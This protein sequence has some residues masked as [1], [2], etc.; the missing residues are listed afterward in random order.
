VN[1][2]APSI[3]GTMREG[4]T[5]T[6]DK[7]S[8][9][10][11]D[12][13]SYAYQWRRCNS[14]GSGCADVAG[15]TSGTYVLSTADS[16]RAVAVRVTGTNNA[17]SSSAASSSV[18]LRTPLFADGFESGL[19][20]WTN[21]GL[22]TWQTDAF[23][24]SSS[25]RAFSSAG[26]ASYA[27]A[28]LSPAQTDLTYRLHFKSNTAS[29]PSTGVYLLKMR[30]AANGSVVG[31]YVTSTGRLSYRNDVGAVA[32]SSPV[33]LTTGEWHEV[34][35]H[36]TIAGTSSSIDLTLDGTHVPA[37]PRT[38][39]FGTAAIGKIQVGDNSTGRNFDVSA[40][41]A[42]VDNGS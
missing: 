41:E 16:G 4:N 7:G 27:T 13:I 29:W 3:S 10:G 30:T 14:D 38:E 34:S 39:N 15:A 35:V 33:I 5:L 19:T 12:P 24:G 18:A 42:I 28:P 36:V 17:G 21:F 37:F 8:W 11:S 1:T 25:A 22:T 20:R 32:Y 2:T 31:V 6:A 40:D 23:A 26:T 9:S